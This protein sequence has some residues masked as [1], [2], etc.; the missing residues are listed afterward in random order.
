MLRRLRNLRYKSVINNFLVCVERVDQEQAWTALQ[1]LSKARFAFA[2]LGSTDL[3]SNDENYSCDVLE[4]IIH[5]LLYSAETGLRATKRTLQTITGYS[6]GSVTGL[7]ALAA[8]LVGV[9]C[10]DH[11]QI[12]AQGYRELLEK[13]KERHCI[14]HAIKA[15]GYITPSW[16]LTLP[17]ES[18]ARKAT[19]ETEEITIRRVMRFAPRSVWYA[20]IFVVP[21]CLW[22][23]TGSDRIAGATCALL[24]FIAV[25]WDARSL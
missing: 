17:T 5:Q 14:V 7:F 11:Q 12:V 9:I 13:A 18:T 10:R 24:F 25:F 15:I 4:D 23:I 19:Q 16:L 22:L 8:I 2:P 6:L 1:E 20:I 21:I 3:L